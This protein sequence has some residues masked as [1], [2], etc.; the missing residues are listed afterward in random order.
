MYEIALGFSVF[1]F[2]AVSVYFVRQ[3]SF[4]IYHPLTIYGAFHGLV[5]VFRPILAWVINY[6]RIY[7][8]F[9]FTPSLDDKLTVIYASNLGFLIFATTCLLAGNRPMTFKFDQVTLSER[10]RLKPLFFWVAAICLPIGAYSLAKGWNSA[11]LTGSAFSGMARDAATGVSYNLESNG[12]LVEAQLML[13]SCAAIIAWLFR[14]RLV[15]VMPML[16][17]VVFRAGTGGRGPFVT[18]LATVALLYLYERRRR[19]PGIV[20]LAAV[21]FLMIVF[22]AV[23][24][25][26]GAAVRRLVGYD[27]TSQVFGP[28][29]VG[30]RPLEGMDFANLEFFEY[31]V[32]VVPQRSQTY[33]YFTDILQ[34]FTE[35]IP[36]ALWKNKPIGA[37]IDRIHLFKFGNPVGMTGSLPGEGWMSLGWFGV[38]LWCG[39]WGWGLGTIYRKFVDGPQGT[40][41]TIAYMTFV[42]V[43]II[44]FRDGQ[45]ITLF[46]QGIFFFAPI[47]LWWAFAKAIGIPSA[48][49]VRKAL[50]RRR[51]RASRALAE[52]AGQLQPQRR[53]TSSYFPAAVLRRRAALV[54]SYEPDL[55]G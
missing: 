17:F 9:Q 1:C 10:A 24:D 26:R 36:R 32:Y 2:L 34:V 3:S 40:F 46:R 27:S 53:S 52:Q 45:V 37:P 20:F 47:V 28:T 23:G 21:P 22:Q 48:S 14:F 11:A 33:G 55:P 12:Y 6:D 19:V 31:A 4:S 51:L 39:L 35:P 38:L 13:A 5:F 18:A 49:E 7:G 29:R 8:Y 16:A 42:P 30:E 15:A 41:Q 54:G 25:D 44:V 43:L 50:M